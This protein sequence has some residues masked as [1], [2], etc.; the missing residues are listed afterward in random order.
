MAYP[1]LTPQ[2]IAQL[3]K[4]AAIQTNFAEGLAAAIPAKQARAAELFVADGAFKKFFDY[5]KDDI[6][7][8]YDAEKKA[9]SGSYIA[10]PITE[11]DV[12]GPANLNGAVRTTPTMP[13]T[14]IIRVTEFDGGG[15]TTTN[16][17]EQKHITDQIP[18]EDHLVNGYT[19][20]P[21]VTV[22]TLTLTDVDE[23]STTVDIEDAV[24]PISF[25]IGD[26][27]V[28][29]NLTDSVL[30]R[31]TSVT[32]GVAIPPPYSVTLGIQVIIPPA[33]PIL[34]G[35]D[36]ITFSGFNNSDR[37]TKTPVAY[38]QNIMN[39][40]IDK[41]EEQIN[42][43]L[44]RLVEELAAVT[45]NLDPDAVTQLATTAS[46]IE[47]SQDFLT[48]YL[49][50][51]DISDTGLGL[52]IA[53]RVARSAQLVTRLS[54]ISANYTGQTENYYNRRYQIANDRGNTSRGTLRLATATQA[55]A[56]GL[57][58]YASDAQDAADAINALLP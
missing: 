4:E 22:T 50:T 5:Y 39:F 53:E 16:L 29:K 9:I 46:N 12:V 24:D 42:L 32:P 51:T 25:S 30:V 17:N 21:T 47:D 31:V 28:I 13:Q 40:L 23:L 3:E 55:S 49:I 44:D 27:F 18:W 34:A 57:S 26:Y 19:P 10:S 35:S 56:A 43:R 6:I 20:Q 41:L 7:G 15:L 58:S 37:T 36:C 54:Q 2:E 48:N 14:N 38:M 8:K 45:T 1:V 52:L 11:A 33:D